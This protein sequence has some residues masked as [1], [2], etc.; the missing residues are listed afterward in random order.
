MGVAGPSPT[1]WLLTAGELSQKPAA[2]GS[3]PGR[4]R[5]PLCPSPHLALRPPRRPTSAPHPAQVRLR[6]PLFSPPL[7]APWLGSPLTGQAAPQLQEPPARPGDRA[8]HRRRHVGSGH[9]ADA[10]ERAAGSAQRGH[11]RPPYVEGASS[12]RERRE[13]RSRLLRRTGERTQG[14]R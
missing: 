14:R 5:E 3:S 1:L 11:F 2:A 7:P 10:T 4:Q 6:A 13:A 8:G 12:S 9:A